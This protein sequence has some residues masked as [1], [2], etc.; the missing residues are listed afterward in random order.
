MMLIFAIE[1]QSLYQ[2]Q[3]SRQGCNSH[4]KIILTIISIWFLTTS[5]EDFDEQ[6]HVKLMIWKFEYRVESF[7][8]SHVQIHIE[9]RPNFK[10]KEFD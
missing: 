3:S 6:E 2:M 5:H 9:Q 10:G 7:R 8:G 1:P 4:I